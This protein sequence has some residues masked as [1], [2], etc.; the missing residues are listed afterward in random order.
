[1]T[2]RLSSEFWVQAYLARLSAEG[3]FAH[4]AYKGDM[5]AGAIAVKVATM[6]GRASVFTRSYGPE[7]DRIWSTHVDDAPES[8]ADAAIEKQRRFDRDLWVIEVEDPR[9]RHLLDQP[10]L[11]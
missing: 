7:G 2:P 8:D 6:Q 9:G 1:M 11:E 10:G 3:I 5:T 4:V